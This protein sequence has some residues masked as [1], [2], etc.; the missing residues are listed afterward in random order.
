MAK[1]YSNLS[2]EELQ[3]K[4]LMVV[5]Y[6]IETKC[7][8]RKAAKYATENGFPIS[9][10][11]VHNIIHKK[12][13]TIDMEKYQKV[14]EILN[15]NTPKSIED[16]KI[17]VRIYSAAAY[18]LQDFTIPEIAKML[19]STP[20]IIYDDLT[21]RLPR[22]DTSLAKEVKRKFQEH[23]L[24]NLGQY[25]EGVPTDVI[26]KQISEISRGGGSR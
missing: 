5:D 15:A 23:K 1:T 2:E 19:D 13:P 16:A 4:I 26:D 17:K 9:N 21:S 12:L 8:T 18:V 22:L 6:I 10:V 3:E 20:D 14:V 24:E 7:S 11:S 25:N